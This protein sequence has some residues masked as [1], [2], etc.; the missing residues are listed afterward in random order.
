LKSKDSKQDKIKTSNEDGVSVSNPQLSSSSEQIKTKKRSSKKKT[1]NSVSTIFLIT[2]FVVKLV[3]LLIILFSASAIIYGSR[4][5]QNIEQQQLEDQKTLKK[6]QI[7]IDALNNKIK[8]DSKIYQEKYS[9]LD[10]YIKNLKENVTSNSNRIGKLSYPQEISILLAEAEYSL[11]LAES[12]MATRNSPSEI[13]EILVSLDNTLGEL[14]SFNTK[15]SRE[16]L[17]NIISVLHSVPVVNRAEHYKKLNLLINH[18]D[19]L[20]LIQSIKGFDPIIETKSS[21]PSLQ[22]IPWKEKIV[23]CIYKA[24]SKFKDFVRVKKSKNPPNLYSTEIEKKYL[25]QYLKATFGQAQ[26]SLLLENDEIYKKSLKQ[27]KIVL[28]RHYSGNEKLI[29]TYVEQI[30]ELEKQNIIQKIPDISNQL[31]SLKAYIRMYKKNISGDK[32]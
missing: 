11:W 1:I 31:N 26:I 6:Y 16:T 5:I 19:Q 3:L 9:K 8:K 13:I 4:L 29:K 17:V 23:A 27:A 32:K 7:E 14:K 25:K 18:L 30:D 24:F 10:I 22:Q 20:P 21:V 28:M 2:K 12:Y 15:E